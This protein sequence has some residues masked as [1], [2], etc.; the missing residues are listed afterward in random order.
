MKIFYIFACTIILV[1]V[2]FSIFLIVYL[3]NEIDFEN[4]REF[5][6]ELYM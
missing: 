3:P 6:V 4:N 2:I 1:L 5:H